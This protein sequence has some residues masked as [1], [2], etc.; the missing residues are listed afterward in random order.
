MLT[1]APGSCTSENDAA[2]CA[3]LTDNDVAETVEQS[4]AHVNNDLYPDLMV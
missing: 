4:V 2:L 1:H 3:H